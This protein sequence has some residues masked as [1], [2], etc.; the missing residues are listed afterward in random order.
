MKKV[1]HIL[2]LFPVLAVA[3]FVGCDNPADSK[4]S[5][6]DSNLIGSW[7][8]QT[9]G[10]AFT[11]DAGGFYSSTLNG[12]QIVGGTWTASSSGLCLSGGTPIRY[13]IAAQILTLDFPTPNSTYEKR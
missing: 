11:F 5:S 8:Q 10:Y 4:V 12:G 9:G 3:L 7:Q 13:S 6:N 1:R 2:G